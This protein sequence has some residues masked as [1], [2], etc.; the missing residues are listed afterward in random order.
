MIVEIKL[1]KVKEINKIEN[2]NSKYI[3]IL[4]IRK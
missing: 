4:K 3:Y 2:L 1:V